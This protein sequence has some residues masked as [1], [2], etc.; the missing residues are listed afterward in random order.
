[1]TRFIGMQSHLERIK[2]VGIAAGF[3]PT[4][5]VIAVVEEANGGVGVDRDA[6]QAG[7]FA[8]GEIF[9]QIPVTSAI[10]ANQRLEP[11]ND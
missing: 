9:A 3:F 6:G 7:S 2:S 11:G 8:E 10:L 4:E 1:M 5:A